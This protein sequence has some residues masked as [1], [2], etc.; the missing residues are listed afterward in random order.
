[1]IGLKQI[2]DV[3]ENYKKKR[4]ISYFE[5]A[6]KGYIRCRMKNSVNPSRAYNL[7]IQPI[8][9]QQLLRIR[10]PEIAEIN[11]G[12]TAAKMLLLSDAESR[13]GSIEI[14]GGSMT[15]QINHICQADD[16]NDP[17]PEVVEKLLDVTASSLRYIEMIVVHGGMLDAGIPE[18]CVYK[19][20]GILFP[21]EQE[22][23][24]GQVDDV[25]E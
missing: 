18:V 6:D 22:Y 17:P 16:K 21:Q 7:I 11:T 4:D 19:I 8:F 10:V 2:T 14:S 20:M 12:S 1:M 9:D 15:F 3:L 25:Q 24:S 5:A 23:K 13:Y